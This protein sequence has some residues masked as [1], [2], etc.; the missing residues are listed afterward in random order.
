M[1]SIGGSYDKEELVKMLLVMR[2]RS[3][4]G[5]ALN[6]SEEFHIGTGRLAIIDLKS[7][8]L[9]PYIEDNY[10]LAFNGEIYNYIEIRKE[11]KKLGWRFRTSSDIEVVLK[12]Y[13]QW[14]KDCLDKFNGMFSLAISDGNYVFLA[15]D[16]AGEKPLYFNKRPFKF[17]SEAKALNWKCEEFK[18]AHWMLFNIKTKK[19]EKYKPYW[20]LTKIKINE[21]TAIRDLEKLLADAIKIR[22]RSDVPYALYYSGGIDS[23]LISTYHKFKHKFTYKDG[24]YAKEFRKKFP[25]ILWHLDY[26]VK[27]FSAFGLYKLAE[28]AKK[29]VKVVISGEGAD[30]LFGGYIR[31]VRPHFNFLAQKTFPSYTGMFQNGESV[32]EAGWREFNGNLGELLRMGD[33]MSSAHGI[34]N[35]CPFLDKRIIQFSFSLQIPL[36]APA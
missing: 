13:R 33:R 24:N 18:P 20:K 23:S 7:D 4:D 10:T 21:K 36:T 28:L 29:K 19:I 25:K 2:H 16:I 15:R 1:C 27:S 9:C 34:E 26:P 3:P 8:G 5:M 17:A 32:S 12:A 22:T 11:L 31:Y 30:E 35:R 6:E 14:G